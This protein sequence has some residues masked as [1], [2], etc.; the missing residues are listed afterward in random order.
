MSAI[1]RDSRL[2]A[3]GLLLV[4]FVCGDV[5][6]T[7]QESGEVFSLQ[8]AIQVALTNSHDINAAEEGLRFANQQVR[9]AWSNVFPDLTANASYQRNLRVQ[10]VFLPARF[11]DPDAPAEAVT[12]VRF[13]SDNTWQAGLSFNQ[14]LFEFDVF[15]GVGAAGRF[16][17]L[18]TERVR[19]TTQS[20]VTVVR[21]AYLDALLAE[22]DLRLT[23]NS[24]ER[25]RQTLTETQALN[26]AGLASNYDVLRLEVQLANIEPNLRRAQ[27]ALDTHKRTLL[28]EMGLEPETPIQLEGRLNDLDISS[29]DA[30]DEANALL[31]GASGL[32][33]E[34]ELRFEELHQLAMRRRTDL[35]QQRLNINLEESRKASQKAEYYPTLSLFSSYN[36]TAQEDGSPTFF[37]TEQQRTTSAIT[38]FRIEVPVFRGFSRD[39]RVQQTNATLRQNEALLERLEKEVENDLRTVLAN[40]EEA[41]DRV[42]SQRRA[43]QQAGRGFEIASAEYREGVGSQLQI[44][45][46]EQA[47]RE[48]EFNHARAVYDYLIA[49]AQLDAIAGTVPVEP[50]DLQV[51]VG[52]VEYE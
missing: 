40:L 20:V 27:N 42:R 17:S 14:P 4:G 41:R 9:E 21:Q 25:V 23:E 45:D 1:K 43:V 15:I 26:R 13:G 30:N 39:A 7:A 31:L 37:G 28:I 35:R 51:R 47:L 24:I 5:P 36:I 44:T 2:V 8:R 18:E 48:S 12:P 19:G 6:A 11:F 10:E 49:R 50:G 46:A 33:F 29:R 22:E 38:G 32:P 3:A 34:A 52:D 16:R